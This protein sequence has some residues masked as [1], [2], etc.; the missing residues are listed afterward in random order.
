M[1]A[2]DVV[3]GVSGGTMA[4]ILGIYERLLNAIRSVNAHWVAL[5]FRA[6]FAAAWKQ[7]DPYF[8]LPLA[9]G[10]GAALIFFTRIVPLP[11]LI[12]SQP[13]LVYGLF[14]GLIVAS[15][16]VLL[17]GIRPLSARDI[18]W[19]VAGCA[20]GLLIVN[21]VPTRTPDASW[22][23]FLC[24]TIAISA[25]LLPGISGS[26]ILLLLQKYAYVFDAIGRFELAVIAPF[27]V[28]CVVGLM[29]FSRV[30]SWLLRRYHRATLL[31]IIGVLIGS[32]WKI[33][34]FQERVFAVIRGK[35]RLIESHPVLPSAMDTSTMSAIALAAVG[36]VLV[37]TID[38][39]ARRR[40]RNKD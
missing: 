12:V 8:V 14:F 26:F 7:L 27:G 35:Q 5:V 30:I 31:V 16:A 24:G 25:M 34:P 4:L 13:E 18:F 29:L 33:W 3:P 2:A 36:T 9:L 22:F 37:L 11:A 19:L 39:V 38:A 6:Q 32:L 15:I 10:I 21:L 40:Q 17:N 1:G 20:A 23:I 28:G